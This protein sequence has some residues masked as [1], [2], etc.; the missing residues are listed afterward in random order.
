MTHRLFLDLENRDALIGQEF[1]TYIE[2]LSQDFKDGF[3]EGVLF[4]EDVANRPE[5]YGQSAAP[6]IKELS[7]EEEQ[8]ILS[9]WEKLQPQLFA[10]AQENMNNEPVA[11]MTDDGVFDY[12][13]DQSLYVNKQTVV[14]LYTHQTKTMTDEEAAGIGL[15]LFRI[16]EATSTKD[17]IRLVRLIESLMNTEKVN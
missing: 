5:L 8:M 9:I 16:G 14:P 7:D 10:N 12:Y 17:G 4:C 2:K 11:W 1:E 3:K 15:H 13:P 6:Q